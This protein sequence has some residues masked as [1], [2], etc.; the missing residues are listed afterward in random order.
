MPNQS[1]RLF[2]KTSFLALPLVP[3]TSTNPSTAPASTSA[4]VQYKRLGLDAMACITDG[5]AAA[6]VNELETLLE[7]YPGDLE[8][9]YVLAVA[10]TQNGDVEKAADCVQRAVDG[11]L[12]FSR[13]QAGPRKLLAPLQETPRF[14]A[15]AKRYGQR[16]L[17]GPLLGQVTDQQ[18]SFWIRTDQEAA[19]QVTLSPLHAPSKTLCSNT[20]YTKK[21]RDFTATVSVR[22]L[23][24]NTK[25]IYQ[26][27]IDGQTV[28]KQ[29]SFQTFPRV[30]QPAEFSIGFGG[31]AGYTPWHERIWRTI[32]QHDLPAFLLTGDNVYIDNPSRPAVQDYC[33][34]RRQSRPEFRAFT[35][36]QS[37]AAIWDDHDFATN[38]SWGGPAVDQPSW[39]QSVWET[40]R[41]NWNNPS[42][43][44]E[45]KRP[46]C[47][48]TFSIADVDVFMLDDRIYR[49][50]PEQ[51]HPTM[52]GPHQKQWLF[53]QLRASNATF[54]LIVSSVPW[55]YGAKPGSKDPWQGYKEERD[56]IFSF[57]NQHR[58][59]GVVLLSGDRHRADVWKLPRTE[60]YDLYEFG[61]GQLTNIHTHQ[62]M[63]KALFSYNKKNMFGKLSFDTTAPDPTV[64]YQIITIDNKP[65][66]TT[67]L[68]R[69]ELSYQ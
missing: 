63:S 10:H 68:R 66:H 30:H 52:L 42:Y 1:R 4:E 54:K 19:F 36:S 40:F 44:Q 46:G 60:A 16:L 32:N 24:P 35:A 37:V 26:V 50:S 3:G 22:Q 69:S 64:T 8:L 6:T 43:G 11:G 39:K 61:N 9:L 38:D 13:F 58:I 31:C 51:T 56:E 45:P 14:Q 29:W 53:D 65:V 21:S 28:E 57:F 5:E 20:S 17:H 12:P 55:A 59:E 62:R 47:W 25:Y 15:F 48:F 2:L 67:T 33:Y 27:A 49:T 34:Y 41:N 7:E 18:A 23:Q